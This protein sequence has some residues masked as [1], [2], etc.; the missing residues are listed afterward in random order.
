MP[1]LKQCVRLFDK[2]PAEVRNDRVI[3][4]P[5]D[6]VLLLNVGMEKID[7]S[8]WRLAGVAVIGVLWPS[9]G[10]C[11]PYVRAP[12]PGFAASAAT[13]EHQE[14]LGIGF[15][16]LQRGDLD[17][18]EAAFG[19]ISRK[20]AR[21]ARA[22]LGLAEVEIKRGRE[23]LAERHLKRALALEPRSPDVLVAYARFHSHGGRYE[24]ALGLLREAVEA[25]PGAY[26][27]HRDLGDLQLNG[28]KRPELAIASYE[29]ALKARSDAVAPRVGIAL[30]HL[31]AQ[32]KALAITALEEAQRLSPKDPALP[33]MIGRIH[34]SEK[35]FDA[36]IESFT[37]AL[38][39]NPEFVPA[40]SDRAD[41]LAEVGSLGPAVADLEKL[42]KVAPDNATMRL[43]LGMVYHRMERLD[44]A[45]SS[46]LAALERNDRL[47]VAYNNLAMIALGRGTDSAQASR[48][49]KRAVELEPS[50]PQFHDTLAWSYQRS[51]D[52]ARALSTLNGA[53]KLEPQQAEIYFRLGQLHEEAGRKDDATKAY[54]RALEVRPDFPQAAATR[55]RIA[56]LLR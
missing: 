33:H 21:N 23:L 37:K 22:E 31:A 20:D 10:N 51:G 29:L 28:F 8:V 46:Y 32:R 56:A 25:D 9:L 39:V 54:R 47:A 30:A 18:A 6:G 53:T 35:R 41:V 13:S 38:V 44:D 49:A 12:Q 11:A 1:T 27:A 50:V 2:I 16:A 48:W 15:R 5:I 34:A 7:L 43:K 45:R 40:L 36:A 19:A 26:S 17:A 4:F 52:L 14:Q 24:K 42:V 55:A 3:D